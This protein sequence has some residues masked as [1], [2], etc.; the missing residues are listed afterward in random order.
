MRLFVAIAAPPSWRDHAEG[1]QH[2]LPERR[3]RTLRFVHPDEMHITLRFIGEVEDADVPALRDALARHLPP[4]DIEL[5]LGR[6]GTFGAPARTS[7]MWLGIEGDLDGLGALHR[8]TDDAVGEALGLIAEEPYTPHL[9]LARV[10]NR[11]TAEERRAIADLARGIQVPPEPF[12]AR[13]A[14]LVRSHLGNGR[15]RYETLATYR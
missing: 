13:E 8:R 5:R 1:I 10:R 15:P 11:V 12:Q 9:T 4:V 2:A 6:V 3:Q 7:V 14:I